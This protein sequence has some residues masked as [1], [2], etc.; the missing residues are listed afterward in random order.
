MPARRRIRFF[1][2][3][4]LLAGAVAGAGFA[5]QMTGYISDAACGWNNA[6]PGKEA[7]ECAVK[8][9]RAGWDP[10]FVPDGQAETFKVSDKAK[11]LPYVGEHVVLVGELKGGL[12]AVKSVRRSSRARR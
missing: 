9:V 8:C 10:V 1:L 6:R 4:M 3:E 2:R 7:K 12:V 5:G 11:V